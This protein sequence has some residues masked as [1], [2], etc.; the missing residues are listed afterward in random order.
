MT[1]HRRAGGHDVATF[2]ASLDQGLDFAADKPLG[3]LLIAGH[4]SCAPV[5]QVP[6]AGRR[7]DERQA[8]QERP[9]PLFS[10]GGLEAL[11]QAGFIKVQRF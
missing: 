4:Q 7:L 1:S 5:Q 2:A 10:A 3:Q 6:P 11:I 8:F 9:R